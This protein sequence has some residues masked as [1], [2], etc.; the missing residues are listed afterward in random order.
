MVLITLFHSIGL[1]FYTGYDI[2]G[3]FKSLGNIHQ[4][5]QNSTFGPDNFV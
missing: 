2:I 5:L 4:Y 3:Q 1:F